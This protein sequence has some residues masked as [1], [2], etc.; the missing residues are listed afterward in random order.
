[1]SLLRFREGPRVPD[2]RRTSP[3]GRSRGASVT[4]PLRFLSV[5]S[6]IEAASVAWAPL[7]WQAAGF[8]EIDPFASAVLSAR[9]GA[10]RPLFMPSPEIPDLTA[11]DRKRRAAAI[12]AVQKLPAEGRVPNFGNLEAWKDWPDA[13]FDVLVGGTPCQSFS[14]A[15]LRKGLDDPRGNLALVYLALV[16]RY[17]PRW[18]V[19]E[20][21]PG[22][23][24]SSKGRDFGSFLGG[25]GELGY[26]WAYRVL[27]AQFVRTLLFRGAVPQRRRRVFVVGYHGG[28][29]PPA[30]VLFDAESLRGNP[31]PSRTTGQGASY[32]VAPCLAASGRGFDRPGD[33][34]GQDCLIPA[35]SGALA[36]RDAKAPRAEDNV[37]IIAVPRSSQV[38]ASREVAQAI[39]ANYSKQP[40]NSDTAL[41]PNLVLRS[42]VAHTLR[43]EGF[44]ASEDGTGR[45]TPIVPVAPT[46]LA[47]GNTTGGHR[48]PGSTVDTVE[49]LIVEGAA[50]TDR[51]W[52]VRR[53]TPVECERLQGFPD[54][55]TDIVSGGR[56]WT[57]DGPRYRA[58]GNS[59]AVNVMG[60]I[61]ER[62][63]LVDGLGGHD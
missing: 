40:D 57:P 45:G 22:V 12:R 5:C 15:G 35:V 58:L 38:F 34:R 9:H 46:L 2:L 61:G 16:D 13:A 60:W 3:G 55:Y 6:G 4:A 17:R 30:A 51:R 27:D 20:N 14:V 26:G 32:D 50:P 10:G 53:L 29:R 33:T 49:S 42:E 54:G 39:T 1:M 7:G 19:W 52:A 47:L 31:P 23:L 21:V 48:P 25:L 11:K 36:A 56:N 8:A 28:W 24:S 59:M 37:G 41:G 44:D 43:A 62:I 18:I 63:A